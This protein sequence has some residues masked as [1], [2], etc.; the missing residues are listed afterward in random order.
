MKNLF[1]CHTCCVITMN[2]KVI[3]NFLHVSRYVL[4][5][6]CNNVRYDNMKLS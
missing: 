2:L 5:Q 3:L 6:N 4:K 1:V